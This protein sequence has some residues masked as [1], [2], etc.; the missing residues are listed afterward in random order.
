MQSLLLTGCLL[1]SIESSHGTHRRHQDPAHST[2][3]YYCDASDVHK[4]TTCYKLLRDLI[5]SHCAFCC[6]KKGDLKSL[7]LKFGP[8]CALKSRGT[9]C[10][11]VDLLLLKLVN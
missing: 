2:S 11:L 10:Q 1:N 6:N 5:K 9:I 7:G 4:Q 3:V 8:R